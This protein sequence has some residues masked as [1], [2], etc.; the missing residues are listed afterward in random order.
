MQRLPQRALVLLCTAFLVAAAACGE[1]GDNK[2]T[3][4]WL[5]ALSDATH[6]TYFPIDRGA[7]KAMDCNLCHGSFDSF[8]GFTCTGT[9]HAH[10]QAVT[11]AQHPGVIG[12]TYDPQGCYLC[13]QNGTVR[14]DLPT[15]QNFFPIGD[16]T[17]HNTEACKDCH[18][19]S[20]R[21]GEVAFITCGNCH[22]HSQSLTDPLHTQP[23]DG[24]APV[25]PIYSWSVNACIQCHLD[26]RML[27]RSEH[28]PTKTYN[29]NN[30]AMGS[31]MQG[32]R[33]SDCHLTRDFKTFTCSPC[34]DPG[35]FA[36]QTTAACDTAKGSPCTDLEKYNYFYK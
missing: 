20:N 16:Q 11:D 34:H 30:V 15:H 32:A 35:G 2:H 12:Y 27:L 8:K 13:H 3:N 5:T 19:D 17:A 22:A 31:H 26:G 18:S 9:C 21:L 28:T 14:F 4:H 36:A 25:G 7:H 33:C 23:K 10:D 1:V 24:G 6:T 29:G